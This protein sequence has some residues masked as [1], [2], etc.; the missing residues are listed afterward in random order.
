MKS[1]ATW[2]LKAVVVLVGVVSLALCIFFL[3]AV[4]KDAEES[5]L[6][7]LSIYGIVT[8]MYISVIPFFIALVQSL[9][10]LNLIDQENAFSE[11]SVK[12]LKVIKFCAVTI[13]C[14]YIA[15]MP[16]FYLIGEKDDAPGAIVIGMVFVFASLVIAVFAAILQM[17]LTNA[18][19]IKSENDLTV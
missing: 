13:C 16:F 12:A 19:E 11:S 18:I 15:T 6:F 2:F 7:T 17:L 3:P 14:V 10:L 5:S 8:G 1:G 9:K 4:M